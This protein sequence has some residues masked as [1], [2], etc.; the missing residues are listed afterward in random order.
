[1][2][3]RPARSDDAGAILALTRR[4]YA[5]W[6]PVIGCE[7]M[8]MRADPARFIRDHEVWVADGRDGPEAA[9][10]LAVEPDRFEVWN[11]A[12][13][14]EA[15]GTGLGR[16][17]MAF[18]E[19]RAR[20]RG[21]RDI[22]LYTNVRMVENRR[23]YAALGYRERDRFESGGRQA[24]RMQKRLDGTWEGKM[25]EDPYADRRAA[26]RRLH[27]SGCFVQPNPWDAGT[28]RYL[29]SRGFPALATTS[30]GFAFTR[31]RPD[32][33]VPLDLILG[34]IADIVEA[35]PD[36][37][38]NADFEN[39]YADDIPTL[40]RNVEA[41]VAAG[42]AGLSIEDATGQ[43]DDPL[44]DLE[45]AVARVRAAREAIDRTGR[46]V[47]LTARAEAFLS[48]HPEPM[49]EVT[50]RFTAFAEAGADCLYAPG[51]RTA[52]DIRAVIAA[53]GDKPVNVLVSADYG[54]SV[55]EI[56]AL[57]ARRISVGAAMARAAWAAFITSADLLASE[58][59]FRGFAA[60]RPSSILNPFFTRDMKDRGLS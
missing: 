43:A 29:R 14:P 18:A 58:G 56:A 23:W 7:P 53:A 40:Q 1:M 31:A 52:G 32:Q 50:R 16:R 57:G 42:V 30:A 13:A 47:L 11:I 27:E 12:V 3:L 21:H 2:S 54:L 46:D 33:H 24:V 34:Y 37:P 49:A 41:C 10:V 38:V 39:G 59:S 25:G 8:P 15:A 6:V 17:L 60:N 45:T 22:W 44:Y 26:Y 51:V 19:R 5:R 9:L 36:L 4:A 20:E 55:A 28:A 48:G 35:V